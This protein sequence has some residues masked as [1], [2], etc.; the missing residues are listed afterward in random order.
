MMRRSQHTT[1]PGDLEKEKK[2]ADQHAGAAHDDACRCK[3]TAGM[4][5][6]ELLKLMVRDLTFWKKEKKG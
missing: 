5:P 6:A 3:E 4:T 1:A 2:T